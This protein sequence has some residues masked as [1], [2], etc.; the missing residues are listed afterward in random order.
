M[1]AAAGGAGGG[2]AA[3]GGAAAGGAAAGGAAAGGAG[4]AAAGAVPMMPIYGDSVSTVDTLRKADSSF[5]E[6]VKSSPASLSMFANASRFLDLS[7][8]MLASTAPYQAYVQW[9]CI[10]GLTAGTIEIYTRSLFNSA[11]RAKKCEAF[12]DFFR[13]PATWL[14][15]LLWNM[16]R[17]RFVDAMKKGDTVMTK[18]F[19]I[20]LVEFREICKAYAQLDTPKSAKDRLILKLIYIAAGRSGEVAYLTWESLSYHSH[21]DAFAFWWMEVKTGFDKFLVPCVGT[22]DDGTGTGIVGSGFED[23]FKIFADNFAH[24]NMRREWDDV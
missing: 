24:G 12:K 21:M 11:L 1:S 8:E 6:M 16:Q 2:A 10:K 3:A 9:A 19:A 14:Q 13:T 20:Y 18:A 15:R 22:G 5:M 17:D 23:I 4:G 7:A